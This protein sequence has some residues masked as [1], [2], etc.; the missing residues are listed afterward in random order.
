MTEPQRPSESGLV[1]AIDIA[2]IVLLG[3]SLGVAFNG[4]QKASGSSRALPW[5][6]HEKTLAKLE[7]VAGA[8]TPATGASAAIGAPI[9]GTATAAGTPP[10]NRT[11]GSTAAPATR[12]ADVDPKSA[13]HPSAP[14]STNPHGSAPRAPDAAPSAPTSGTSSPPANGSP[15]APA[16][17]NIPDSREP[18][19]A[20]Y[21][22]IKALHVAQA[23][24]FVDA[25]SAQEYAEGH[26]PGAV[27]LPFDDV[28]KKPELAKS[29]ANGGRPIVTY[30]GGGDCELSK[31]LAFALIEAGQRKVLVFLGG[32]PG[33]KDAGNPVS[34]GPQP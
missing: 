29:I 7:D 10:A 27:N 12:R 22:T 31:S 14:A 17:P 23:A 2:T 30:C 11:P 25:R 20:G 18:L 32:L 21:A 5:V 6:A 9:P 3:V 34:T 16:V 15:A 8:A 4:V 1:L 24:L 26:I 19:E 13:A 28:F 33:W